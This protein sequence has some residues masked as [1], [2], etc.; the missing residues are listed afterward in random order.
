MEDEAVATGTCAVLINGCALCFHCTQG[1]VD[2]GLMEM[3]RRGERSLMANLA[4]AEK[5]KISW[6]ESAEVQVNG[7]MWLSLLSCRG[8]RK[9][10]M[11]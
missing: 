10:R 11:G 2:P 9:G 8:G 3:A 5:Y 4:A 1:H 7:C 6:T